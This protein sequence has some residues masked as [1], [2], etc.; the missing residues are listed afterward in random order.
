MVGKRDGRRIIIRLFYWVGPQEFTNNDYWELSKVFKNHTQRQLFE[1]MQKI[2]LLSPDEGEVAGGFNKFK[3]STGK[4]RVDFEKNRRQP[5]FEEDFLSKPC[6]YFLKV[7][8]I[9]T[10]SENTP[11]ELTVA[12]TSLTFRSSDPQEGS[13]RVSTSLSQKNLVGANMKLR[14]KC[15]EQEEKLARQEVELKSAK[16]KASSKGANLAKISKR[17]HA[18]KEVGVASDNVKIRVTKEHKFDGGRLFRGESSFWGKPGEALSFAHFSSTKLNSEVIPRHLNNRASFAVMALQILSGCPFDEVA[19]GKEFDNEL[20]LLLTEII[21]KKKGVFQ[22]AAEA[23][24]FSFFQ[25]ITVAQAVDTK[26]LLRL[27]T[28]GFRRLR[29]KE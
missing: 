2:F 22:K 28:S 8:G 27:S 25:K 24:G 26:S 23:A 1:A 7:F 12:D 20:E 9:E 29:I 17:M 5:N 16:R 13:V 4:F 10:Q 15:K 21:R 18:A 6:M 14:M 3:K 11:A 19:D